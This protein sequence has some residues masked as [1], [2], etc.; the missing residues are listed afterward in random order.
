MGCAAGT[1]AEITIS[2]ARQPINAADFCSC[3][4]RVT[5]LK[6]GH[7]GGDIN[8]GRG[9]AL[10]ILGDL[11]E[12]A[13]KVTHFCLQEI[14]GGMKVNAIPREA[15][16]SL[17]FPSAAQADLIAALNARADKFSEEFREADP[18]LKISIAPA[19]PSQNNALSK[20]A[21]KNIITALVSIPN[22]VLAES[23]EIQGLVDSSCNIGVAETLA[24]HVKISAM[25]RGSARHFT[26]EIEAQISEIAQ[27]IGAEVAFLQRS[28]AWP[29][30]PNS[31][32]LQTAQQVYKKMFGNEATATAVHGGLECGIFSEKFA[33]RGVA[34]DIISLGPTAH[35][36]HTP[37]ERLSISSTAKM[38]QFLQAVLQSL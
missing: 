23:P 11:L 17:V 33:K 34:L 25:P 3:E 21:T 29:Y 13:A 19:A 6:G 28:P 9:N 32:L 22:G 36:Y 37:L 30:N 12:S 5:G 1:T 10:R 18:D 14:S 35:D 31:A 15:V 2:A 16:A 4:I 26:D 27:Q 7:S 24:D 8:T 38:W 20:E